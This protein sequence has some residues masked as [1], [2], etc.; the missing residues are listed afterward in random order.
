MLLNFL[1]FFYCRCTDL[2]LD[3]PDDL[4]AFL[5]FQGDFNSLGS[6]NDC[7]WSIHLWRE[8]DPR[9]HGGFP[10]ILNFQN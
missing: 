3:A 8:H 1:F 2:S 6:H 9:C 7:S 4:I 10:Q 5:S